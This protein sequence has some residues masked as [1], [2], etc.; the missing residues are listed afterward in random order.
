[1]CERVLAE[2]AE[3]PD[4]E[5]LR[6]SKVRLK[7]PPTIKV[8]SE[9]AARASK[10]ASKA[11]SWSTFGMYRLARVKV[12]EWRVPLMKRYLPS[13]SAWTANRRHGKFLA[14]RTHT[15]LDLEVGDVLWWA[16]GKCLL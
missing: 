5:S 16:R 12:C 2:I 15:P 6:G 7:S 8:P 14:R 13:L 11:G 1:M 9:N 3:V 10:H 4:D